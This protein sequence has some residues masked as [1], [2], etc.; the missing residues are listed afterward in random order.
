MRKPY[1]LCWYCRLC[2]AHHQDKFTN[3]TLFRRHLIDKHPPSE[4]VD[5]G[6]CVKQFLKEEA[7]LS[8]T[9]RKRIIKLVPAR[10]SAHQTTR[11]LLQLRLLD[12]TVI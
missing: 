1:P 7:G 11:C 4:L 9:K 6:Y 10:F 5:S 2:P 3:S 8:P 12:P